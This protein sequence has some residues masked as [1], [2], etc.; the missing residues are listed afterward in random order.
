[1]N[2]AFS[3]GALI[4]DLVIAALVIGVIGVVVGVVVRSQRRPSI[5]G[6]TAIIPVSDDGRYW[7]D[8]SAWQDINLNAP[9]HAAR[10]PDGAY[11]WDGKTWHPVP[12]RQ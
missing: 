8:G 4:G 10:S 6:G 9:A 11:W 12:R 5:A 7:W 3:L 2:E 1:M